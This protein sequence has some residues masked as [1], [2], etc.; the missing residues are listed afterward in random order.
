MDDMSSDKLDKSRASFRALSTN[1][2]QFFR[3][4]RDDTSMDQVARRPPNKK[5]V[6][7]QAEQQTSI[8]SFE[9]VVF[10]SSDASVIRKG[11]QI[12]E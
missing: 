5:R 7:R 2:S 4:M 9:G 6:D 11:C 3:K 10:P 8:T 1:I 12:Q